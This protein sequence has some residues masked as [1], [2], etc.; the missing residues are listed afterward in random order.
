MRVSTGTFVQ[1]LHRL[2]IEG[3]P[4]LGRFIATTRGADAS[5]AIERNA[6]D[7]PFVCRNVKDLLQAIGAPEKKMTVLATADQHRFRW[8]EDH[9]TDPVHC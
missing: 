5:I 9:T 6:V 4:E 7:G 8:M 1:P 3:V 2:Q